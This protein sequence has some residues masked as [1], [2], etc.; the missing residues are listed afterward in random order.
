VCG[1]VGAF[2]AE[3]GM[4]TKAPQY[5]TQGLF[6]SV[7][8]GYSGCGVGLISNK[9]KPD[10]V[11]SRLASPD[12]I[13]TK[14]YSWVESNVSMS[15][16]IMGHTRAPTG[17][18]PNHENSHP[19]W[20]V[21]DNDPLDSVILTHNGHVSNYHSLTPAGFKHDVDSAHVTHSILVNGAK[22]TLEK[23]QGYYVLT[24]YSEK[25]KQFHIARNESNRDLFLAKSPDGT[26][27]YYASEKEILQF[28][29]DRLDIPYHA[30]GTPEAFW[31]L[32]PYK[33]YSWDLTKDNLSEPIVESYE[34]K[35]PIYT[36]YSGGGTKATGGLPDAGDRIYVDC[37]NNEVVLYSNSTTHGCVKAIRRLDNG[38]VRIDGVCKEDWE[39]TYKFTRRSLPC[40]VDASH[41]EMVNGLVKFTYKVRINPTEATKD[42]R[43]YLP[44]PQQQQETGEA[45]KKEESNSLGLTPPDPD[46]LIM[47]PGPNDTTISLKEWREIA[48]LGCV[49]CNGTILSLDKDKVKWYPWARCPEDPPEDTEWQLICPLCAK[50]EKKLADIY[51]A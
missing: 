46:S 3:K 22:E 34:Q 28:C 40:I 10:F 33:L 38:E 5:I 36:V 21:K 48:K 35:K 31:Q 1:L 29:L 14:T 51:G 24:W 9:F 17:G 6:I 18:S 19:F 45:K 4:F 30:K 12:F 8:R 7:L 49:G 16:V 44:P 27:M 15:R 26:V 37:E 23:L 2:R 32:D 42:A 25:D 11:K 39:K 13:Q 41:S 50:D 20:Y 47:Y 43:R